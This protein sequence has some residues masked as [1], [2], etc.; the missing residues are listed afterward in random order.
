MRRARWFG[1]G[2]G[3]EVKTGDVLHAAR[4]K[5]LLRNTS[6]FDRFNQRNVGVS[7]AVNGSKT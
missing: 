1:A 4:F 3:G 7:C 2:G 5:V 6:Q